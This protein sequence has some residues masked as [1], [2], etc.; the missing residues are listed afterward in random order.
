MLSLEAGKGIIGTTPA[1]IGSIT[2]NETLKLII[3]FGEPLI[4]KILVIDL[5]TLDIQKINL[6]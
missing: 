5:L 6:T 4:G 3:G 1:V 2:A